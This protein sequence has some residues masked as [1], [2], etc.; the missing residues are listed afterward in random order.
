MFLIDFFL[1]V[2]L[3]CLIFLQRSS[4]AY[5]ILYQLL[6]CLARLKEVVLR[7]ADSG[8]NVLSAYLMLC[9]GC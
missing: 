3:S 7:I 8:R 1:F 2:H 9:S 6:Q 5:I 4:V